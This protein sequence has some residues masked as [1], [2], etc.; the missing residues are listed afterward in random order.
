[1]TIDERLEYIATLQQSHDEH[2]AKLIEQDERLGRRIEALD[3]RI[4]AIGE[5]V[6]VLTERTIQAME[7]IGRLARIAE[8]HEDRISDIEDQ[9]PST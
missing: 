1:M 8:N 3:T 9:R 6:E 2:I 4:E 5:K 7:A